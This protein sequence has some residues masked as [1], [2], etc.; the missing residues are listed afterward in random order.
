MNIKV[1]I[2]CTKQDVGISKESDKIHVYC[3]HLA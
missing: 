2:P 3:F 1:L